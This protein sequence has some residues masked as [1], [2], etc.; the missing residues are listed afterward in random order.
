MSSSE[1]SLMGYREGS[2]H[3]T[4]TDVMLH[5]AL[6]PENCRGRIDPESL[7][8]ATQWSQTSHGTASGLTPGDAPKPA[9]LIPGG[10]GIMVALVD[11]NRV[12]ELFPGIKGPDKEDSTACHAKHYLCPVPG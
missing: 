4:I 11:E 2:R 5:G 12:P 10:R 7:H 3:V 8:R 1:E 6:V 9:Q